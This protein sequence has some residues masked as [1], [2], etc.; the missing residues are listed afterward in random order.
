MEAAVNK[1]KEMVVR[2]SAEAKAKAKGTKRRRTTGPTPQMRAQERT[3]SWTTACI[4]CP[5]VPNCRKTTTA[6]AGGLPTAP[7][8]G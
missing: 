1:L 6:T 5:Q 2:R 4:C 8:A 3:L 7:T